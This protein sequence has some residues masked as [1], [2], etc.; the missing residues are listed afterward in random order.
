M[1]AKEKPLNILFSTSC[2]QTMFIYFSRNRALASVIVALEDKY[3][4]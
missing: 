2:K 3:C 4:K 1:Q